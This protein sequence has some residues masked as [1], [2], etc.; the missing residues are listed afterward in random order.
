MP[1]LRLYGFTW[2]IASDDVGFLAIF[3]AAFHAAWIVLIAITGQAIYHMPREC[4]DAGRLFI[5]TVAGLLVCFVTGFV[6]ECLLIWESC[7]GCIFEVSKRKRMPLL[8]TLRLANALG[9]VFFAAFGTWVAFGTDVRC[10]IPSTGLEWNPKKEVMILVLLTW[11]LEAL[12]LVNLLLWYNA[13]PEQHAP[14][15]W[16][17]RF[18]FLGRWLCCQAAPSDKEDTVQQQRRNSLRRIARWVTGLLGHADLTPS[19]TAIALVLTA[20]LQR[21]CRR[22]RII[23][24]LRAAC[25][26]GGEVAPSPAVSLLERASTIRAL[27]IGVEAGA[28]VAGTGAS[29][30]PAKG[31]QASLPQLDD[32][33]KDV[34]VDIPMAPSE[35]GTAPDV[36]A[37]RGL[38]VES[39]EAAWSG[40]ASLAEPLLGAERASSK[41]QERPDAPKD[42][43]AAESLAGESPLGKF[44]AQMDLLAEA[45][46]TPSGMDEELRGALLPERAVQLY[47]GNHWRVPAELLTEVQHYSK[48]AV[49]VYGTDADVM[50]TSDWW[51]SLAYAV[52]GRTPTRS[53]DRRK[54]DALNAEDART[55]AER[56]YYEGVVQELGRDCD[57]LYVCPSNSA[58][59]HL[60]YL[61]ALDHAT[62]AVVVAVRGTSSVEDVITDSVAEPERLG[63]AWLPEGGAEAGADA[64]F[65]HSGIKAAADSILDD[66]EDSGIL[67]A[68]LAGE[69]G[70]CQ[71]G[72][73]PAE[74]VAEEEGPGRAGSKRRGH[75]VAA[76]V[77]RK[78]DCRGWRL[79]VTGHSLGAGAA[80]LIAMR[81]HGRFPGVRCW[82]FCPPGGLLSTNLS[83][84]V[85]PFVTSVVVGKD[86]VPRVSIVNLGR[87]ID[88]MVT[89]LALCRHNKND[90]LLHKLRRSARHGRAR[91]MFW[92]YNQVPKEAQAVLQ[93]YNAGIEAR[94]RMLELVPPGRVLF[95]RPLKRDGARVAWDAVWCH[96]SDIIREGI[97]VSPRMVEDHYSSTLAAALR[98]AM[99]ADDNE[100]LA[101]ALRYF[102]P[103]PAAGPDEGDG[104]V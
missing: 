65:A 12:T 10:R 68:L 33:G 50:K 17:R 41:A 71:P 67:P 75:L 86:V 96:A 60:P 18:I 82:S 94:S 66:L 38:T 91:S 70:E 32:P 95:L 78:L 5:A 25:E 3:G 47:T 101:S 16:E 48:F 4:T 88:E 73:L 28:G 56:L 2:H 81:L 49:G 103:A 34:L 77:Q 21:Q 54:L 85:A 69:Y 27:P 52:L 19:D 6:L 31:K 74:E 40:A 1:S 99:G 84:A 9:E 39:V 35:T 79:V 44:V 57:L 80:A 89:S 29:E 8:V 7:Q 51:K 24:T 23:Q 46:I 100:A 98:S 55:V 97:L 53:E 42:T 14:E 83:A 30:G 36:H 22:E 37:P 93:A 90:L 13:W 64:M 11:G 87:L 43:G 15:S 26:E 59:A 102:P 61:V 20:T 104:T 72:K 45:T 62:R 76:I 58:L 92:R 63:P